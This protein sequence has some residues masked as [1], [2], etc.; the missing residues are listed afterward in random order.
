MLPDFL[1][2]Y[3][4]TDRDPGSRTVSRKGIS[5][6]NPYAHSGSLSVPDSRK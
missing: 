6:T 4:G 2:E 1:D 3:R 5:Q